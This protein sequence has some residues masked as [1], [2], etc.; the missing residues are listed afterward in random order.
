MEKSKALGALS[1]L[2]NDIRLELVRT[3]VT[4]GSEGMSAG[5]IARHLGLS[6]SRLSFHLS[7][8]EQAGLIASQK[9]ARHVF[10]AVDTAAL[11][12]VIRYLL[13]DCC[14]SHPAVSAC[15]QGIF[16]DPVTLAAEP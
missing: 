9:S 13:N 11:G 4:Q 2:A 12:G 15:C 3:L 16:H 6:P 8:L 5:D 10:Y 1:A 14:R 7:T